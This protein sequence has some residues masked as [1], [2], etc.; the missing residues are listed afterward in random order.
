MYIDSAYWHNKVLDFKDKKYALFVTSCG[1]YR[2]ITKPK[3]PLT[4][5][6]RRTVSPE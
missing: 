1:T 5:N 3:Y 2:L 6:I 4:Q